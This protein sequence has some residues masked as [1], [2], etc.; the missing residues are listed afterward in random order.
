[1]ETN[2]PDWEEHQAIVQRKLTEIFGTSAGGKAGHILMI[3]L[4]ALTGSGSKPNQHLTK[5]WKLE[6]LNQ[7]NTSAKAQ[8]RSPR[9]KPLSQRRI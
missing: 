6:S 1:M 2:Q 9:H 3:L 8:L 5:A 4:T 7:D